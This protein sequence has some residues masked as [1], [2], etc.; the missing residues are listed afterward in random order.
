MNEQSRQELSPIKSSIRL[1]TDHDDRRALLMRLKAPKLAEARR[2][3]LERSRGM[4]EL[5]YY[6]E[7]ERFES[8]A[9]DYHVVQFDITPFYRAASVR[10]IFEVCL[11]LAM[12]VEISISETLDN[13]TIRENDDHSF[14][15]YGKGITYHRLASINDEGAMVESSFAVFHEFD[16]DSFDGLGSGLFVVEPIDEDEMHPFRSDERVRRDTSAVVLISPHHRKVRRK[17]PDG[18]EV[19]EDEMVVTLKRWSLS[20]LQHTS[21]TI[22]PDAHQRLIDMTGQ[23]MNEMIIMTRK[24][25]S[26]HSLSR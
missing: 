3:I 13:I 7:E 24:R 22:A 12:N 21:L 25:L 4:D 16:H 9:G 10:S 23:W 18:V 8:D 26:V 20:T 11:F 17:N 2:F 1:G 19:E 15:E 5:K 14:Q 6:K